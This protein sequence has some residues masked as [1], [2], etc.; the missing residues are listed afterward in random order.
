MEE[1]ERKRSGGIYRCESTNSEP[2]KEWTDKYYRQREGDR[3]GRDEAAMERR[4][5][6]EIILTSFSNLFRGNMLQIH[7]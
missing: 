1:T 4:R 3:G 2:L 5:L 7:K 6:I